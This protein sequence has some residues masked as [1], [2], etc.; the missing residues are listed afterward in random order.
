MVAIF[1]SRLDMSQKEFAE[2]LGFSPQYQSDIEA[3][4][5]SPSYNYVSQLVATFNASGPLRSQW[6]LAGARSH[7][8]DI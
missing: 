3:G 4:R 7:G 6:M 2:R 1:R 8:W 5:R